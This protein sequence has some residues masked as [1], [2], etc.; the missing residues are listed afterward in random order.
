[1][2]TMPVNEGFYVTSGFGPRWGSIHYGVDFGRNG[3]S[4]G[5][6]VFAV[7]DGTV[8]AAGPA[9]GFGQWVTVDHPA[10]NGGGLTVYGH[11]IP[12]VRV[13][14][15]VREGQRIAR[16]NPD[17][18]TNGGVA[19]H[20]HLEWHRYVWSPPG[21]N[22][23][24]PMTFLAGAKWPGATVV[25][26]PPMKQPS[27]TYTQLSTIDRGWRDPNTVPLIAV[28][29]YE[30]PRESGE[31]AL[32]NRADYQ[33]R[34]GTGSYTVLVSADGKSLRANDDNYTPCA[35]LPTGDRL[36]F[37]LSFLAYAADSRET[38][39]KYEAQLREAARI[40]ADWCRLYGHEPRHLSVGEVAS[41]KVKGFCTHGDIS[42]AFRESDHTDP[43]KG[44][45]MDVFLR[46]VREALNPAP[47]KEDEVAFTEDDRKMLQAVYRELTQRYPSR[48]AYRGD[49]SPV[50]TLAGL[51]LNVDGR[52]HEDWVHA[53]AKEQGVTPDE[54]AR[55]L[56]GGKR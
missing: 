22:R 6:P 34:S 19:P 17:S 1:M 2:P 27:T 9:S 10:S 23:L 28:H 30:C 33:Q 48:S 21:P 51:L 54:F 4:G 45:P 20:L 16:I 11:V 12:E 35:S 31:K 42:A 26:E 39:L 44:F 32:R 5:H 55:T 47:P 18:R 46:Y 3:G 36:G 41:R 50:D 37:H 38:W 52:V 40:C 14:Q 53:R 49:D 15:S 24:D 13:G 8:T 43:G 7:K 29:T 25:K 56:N